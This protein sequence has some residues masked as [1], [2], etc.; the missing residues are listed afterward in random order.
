M[1]GLTTTDRQAKIEGLTTLIR[2]PANFSPLRGLVITHNSAQPFFESRR[3]SAPKP[4]VATRSGY[5]GFNAH[6][7]YNASGVA[8]SG[9]DATPLGLFNPANVNPG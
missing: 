2:H 7:D 5:T 4:S 1:I 9:A 3:D 6:N 8:Q